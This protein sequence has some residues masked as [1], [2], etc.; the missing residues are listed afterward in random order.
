MIYE[1]ERERERE[2]RVSFLGGW[3]GVGKGQ[4]GGCIILITCI[5]IH[6]HVESLILMGLLFHY[7]YPPKDCLKCFTNL[8]IESY[9]D[10]SS[11]LISNLQITFI[12]FVNGN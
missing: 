10:H 1:R 9:T 7:Y 2:R 6:V 3:G 4:K 5:N 11:I 8:I 12:V